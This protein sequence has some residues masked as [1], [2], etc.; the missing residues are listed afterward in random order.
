[1]NS[2]QLPDPHAL[3]TA[4]RNARFCFREM[5]SGTILVTNDRYEHLFLSPSEFSAWLSGEEVA[6]S[7]R[8]KLTGKGFVQSEPH[9]LFASAEGVLL[10]RAREY[11]FRPTSLF[12]FVLTL[13]CDHRCVYCQATKDRDRS[14]DTQMSVQTAR[15]AVE[16]VF[17]SPSP[18]VTIEF[19]GGEPLKNFNTLAAT[20]DYASQ[21]SRVSGKH[22]H[23]QVSTNLQN[24]SHD[25]AQF[26]AE[27]AVSVC[28][29]C[30]GPQQLHDAN[31][32]AD[33][34]GSSFAHVVHWVPVL[35]AMF[36]ERGSSA[37]VTALA[38]VT[39]R[40]LG[41]PA[42]IVNSYLALGF[43]SL[44]LRPV[45][46]FGRATLRRDYTP[47]EFCQFY[48]TALQAV[49]Q[50]AAE[51]RYIR[52]AFAAMF[53]RKVFVREGGNFMELRSPC[54]V[55][56]GQVAFDWNGDVY[57]C[58]EG[59]M[60]GQSGDKTFCI[61]HVAD[62]GY[63]QWLSHPVVKHATIAS[64]IECHPDCCDCAFG[65]FCG[66]CPVY[67]YSTQDCLIGNMLESQMCHIRRT[68]FCHLFSL[69][70]RN[71]EEARILRAWA[72]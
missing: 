67:N 1:M 43:D 55:G 26:L 29:S 59:R 62:S 15:T 17:E 66:L 68:L 35:N 50:R 13:E 28:T 72:A 32:P 34:P 37:K 46:P 40:S 70:E 2:S 52:E 54:G 45:S 51:G 41:F 47:D 38:T 44:F 20:V 58:D 25:K 64:C 11:L 57:T 14:F 18:Q 36:E 71:G 27:H 7:V 61:G 65:P 23:F 24:M 69:L 16:R 19:Q 56:I 4:A 8:E 33:E 39:R 63:R 3:R 60:L 42:E 5:E 48:K 30:D 6:E 49:F 21:L 31:R 10:A 53:A 12:I 9:E 22:V